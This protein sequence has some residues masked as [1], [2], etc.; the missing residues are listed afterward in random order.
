MAQMVM[1]TRHPIG[2][3]PEAEMVVIDVNAGT[4]TLILDDGER[5]VMQ[6]NEFTCALDLEM[7]ADALQRNAA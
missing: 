5:I 7:A 4:L 3:A 1:S 6:A 2:S